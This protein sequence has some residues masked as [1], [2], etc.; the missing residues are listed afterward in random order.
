MRTC[1]PTLPSC[2]IFY[3][4]V[5]SPTLTAV[6]LFWKT[7]PLISHVEM[8]RYHPDANQ[9]IDVHYQQDWKPASLLHFQETTIARKLNHKCATSE[10]AP[11]PS[12]KETP[13]LLLPLS[14]SSK[15]FEVFLQERSTQSWTTVV[16]MDGQSSFSKSSTLLPFPGPPRF[17]DPISKF[18]CQLLCF[19]EW[20]YCL[21]PSYRMLHS[22][23]RFRLSRATY[24]FLLNWLLNNYNTALKIMSNSSWLP[25]SFW[26][27]KCLSTNRCEA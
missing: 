13:P 2:R 26:I 1:S 20:S 22:R 14:H 3:L 12:G 18:N 27:F 24:R 8:V 9:H 5:D 19:G 16:Q 21:G 11:S 15:Q 17:T 10:R 4:C 7:I 6:S 25:I 23:A